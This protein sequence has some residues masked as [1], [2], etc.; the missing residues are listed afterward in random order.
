MFSVSSVPLRYEGNLSGVIPSSLIG[1]NNLGGNIRVTVTE[2][3]T[4]VNSRIWLSEAA[5]NKIATSPELYEGAFH[6][7]Q[8]L[9]K[10]WAGPRCGSEPCMSDSFNKVKEN[11]TKVGQAGCDLNSAL[12]SIK[13]LANEA[14]QYRCDL[15][16][17]CSQKAAWLMEKVC[18]GNDLEFLSQDWAIRP[19]AA[20]LGGDWD[21][22]EALEANNYFEPLGHG[23]A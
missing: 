18:D 13:N 11:L 21:R 17:H 16:T 1:N 5:K 12:D 10:G 6:T 22:A 7:I 9:W 3:P 23:A 2:V 4:G 14:N 15:H 19:P 8:N 20:A